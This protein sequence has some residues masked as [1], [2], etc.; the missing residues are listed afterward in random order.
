M[1]VITADQMHS[2]SRPDH[3]ASALHLITTRHPTLALPPER[4]AGDELQTLVKDAATV[5]AVVLDLHR[6]RQWSIGVG[7]G[8]VRRPLPPSIREATGGA[9]FAARKAVTRAKQRNTRFAL[10]N[11]ATS[12]AS[13]TADTEALIDLLLLL[14]DRRTTGG[15]ELHDLLAT[16]IN[17]QEAAARLG[18][19]EPAVSSRAR[20]AGIRAEQSALPAL[21]TLLARLDDDSTEAET[22]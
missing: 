5:L 11:D 19:S 1:F 12:A 21:A 2:R 6:E 9:F 20:A 4:T 7:C 10:A 8:S 17:Q 18:I 22:T 14:R 13:Q 15:W 3:V 16:G